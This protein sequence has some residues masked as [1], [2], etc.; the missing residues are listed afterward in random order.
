VRQEDKKALREGTTGSSCLRK[1]VKRVKIVGVAK[2]LPR[3]GGELADQVFGASILQRT[4]PSYTAS[5]Q[6]HACYLSASDRDP[7]QMPT[8]SHNII[9]MPT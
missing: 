2:E 1:F 4:A 6:Y 5:P 7:P 9:V 8:V 3:K